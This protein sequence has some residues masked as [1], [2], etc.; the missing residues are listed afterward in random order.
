MDTVTIDRKCGSCGEIVAQSVSFQEIDGRIEVGPYLAN[1]PICKGFLK[2]P[3]L[4]EIRRAIILKREK[5]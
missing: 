2:E 3:T 1:C 5:E 4:G